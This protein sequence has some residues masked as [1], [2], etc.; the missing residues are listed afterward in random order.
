MKKALKKYKPESLLILGTSDKMIKKIFVLSLVIVFIFQGATLAKKKDKIPNLSPED[1]VKIFVE[2]EDKTTF[3]ELDT[4]EILRGII[5]EQLVEKKIFN[6]IGDE[7]IT[8]KF[9]TMKSLG[10]KKSAADVG[11]LLYF[12]PAEL[13]YGVTDGDLIQE[14]YLSR[15]IEY[16]IK[17]QILAIGTTTKASDLVAF[18]PGFGIGIGRR[19]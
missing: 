9:S 4:A 19:G 15:G 11:D 12:N 18:D 2:V 6:V 17:C 14:K 13:S 8:G 16:V 1:R 7:E 5:S 10:E 3:R